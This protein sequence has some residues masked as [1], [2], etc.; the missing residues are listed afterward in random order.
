MHKR[1]LG[2]GTFDGLH[3]G[4]EAYLS[5]LK[6]LGETFV[7]VARDANVE[8]I[9][10]AAPKHDEQTRLKALEES[11]FVDHAILGHE[12]DFY[13]HLKPIEPHIIGLGYDQEADDLK[14][15]TI[16]TGA[17]IKRLDPFEPDKYKSTI[18]NR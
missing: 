14:L 12:T 4:H 1:V 11:P 9:K 8:R 10:G 7:V 17:E 3:K 6:E 13:S 2:F 16:F 15:K 5:Q 18:L